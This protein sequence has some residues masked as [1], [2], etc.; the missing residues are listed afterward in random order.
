[1]PVE[2]L[3]EEPLHGGRV[4]PGVVRVGDTVRKLVTRNSA[5]VRRFLEHLTSC[6]SDF[7]PRFL[8]V[9]DRNRDVFTFIE[10]NVPAD[11]AFF[12]DPTLCKAASLIRRYHD[13]SSGFVASMKDEDRAIDVVCHNDLSPCNFVFRD[14][15]PVAIIDF[16]AS[17]PGTRAHDLGYAA[18]L[19]LDV[20]S[21]EIS[22]VE[23]RQRLASF[24]DAY[25][26]LSVESVL[27]AMLA[28]QMKL[29][30]EAQQI[31]DEGMATWAVGCNRWTRDN[32]PVLRGAG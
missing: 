18:W 31:G 27:E 3:D 32:L 20:G 6:G 28:R 21:S 17:G 7:S 29:F 15:E 9:D 4:S 23:Q 19:W 30:E 22:V 24:V 8:H 10:G 16:D 14:E 12:D 26:A 13:L 2:D 5:F 11:L 1:M 25:G